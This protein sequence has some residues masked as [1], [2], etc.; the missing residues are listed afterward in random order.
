MLAA[1][2]MTTYGQSELCPPTTTLLRALVIARVLALALALV[3]ALAPPPP[4]LLRLLLLL[5]LLR[6]RLLLLSGHDSQ[7]TC[8]AARKDLAP[9]IHRLRASPHEAGSHTT[10]SND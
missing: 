9:G 6:R 5:R 10:D 3:L 4:R 8:S 2:T 1:L 7:E